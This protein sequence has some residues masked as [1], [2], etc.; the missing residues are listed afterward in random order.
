MELS[1][2]HQRIERAPEG[3]RL[4]G[5]T[6]IINVDGI[7]EPFASTNR[8]P[9]SIS[10]AESLASV[11]LTSSPSSDPSGSQ[12]LTYAVGSGS[13]PS[14]ASSVARVPE[15]N[16]INGLRTDADDG[17]GTRFRFGL[18]DDGSYGVERFTSGGARQT[19]TWS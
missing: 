3:N 2:Q 11:P 19:L 10:E 4:F 8:T 9:H 15:R 1:R 17:W 14:S 16:A 18:L 7:F 6:G 5:I 13:D 12:Q